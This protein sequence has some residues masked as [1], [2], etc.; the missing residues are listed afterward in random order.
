MV[1]TT[2]VTASVVAAPA[3]LPLLLIERQHSVD[4]CP[5]QLSCHGETLVLWAAV[6]VIGFLLVPAVFALALAR[7]TSE[8]PGG[9]A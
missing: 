1:A 7:R 4:G 6:F 8:P 2:F 3:S 9:R 5:P